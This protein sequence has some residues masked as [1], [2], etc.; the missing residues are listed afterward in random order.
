MSSLESVISILSKFGRS[1]AIASTAH[2][3]K[4][5]LL[6]AASQR[7]VPILKSSGV[8]WYVSATFST[9][10]SDFYGFLSSEIAITTDR[11]SFPDQ[12]APIEENNVSALRMAINASSKKFVYHIDSDRLIMGLAYFPMETARCLEY[13]LAVAESG[14]IAVPSRDAFAMSTHHLPLILTESV[15]NYYY[16]RHFSDS[17]ADPGTTAYIAKRNVIEDVIRGYKGGVLEGVRCDFPE[18]KIWLLASAISGSEIKFFQAG[19]PLRYEAPEQFRGLGIVRV[20]DHGWTPE[21]YELMNLLSSGEKARLFL[22][23]QEW[24]LRFKT[25]YQYLDVL[26]VFGKASISSEVFSSINKTIQSDDLTEFQRTASDLFGN[27]NPYSK[28]F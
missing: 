7:A 23:K 24:S 16:S 17:R 20:K 11:D 22:E 28:T 26:S 4:S 19:N 2:D 14:S 12:E 27:S 6:E 9:K 21:C 3:P 1:V 5:S 10:A 13:A 18:P 15:I 8:E 25:L